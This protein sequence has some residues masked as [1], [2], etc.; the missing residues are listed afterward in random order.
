MDFKGYFC[1]LAGIQFNPLIDICMKRGFIL[2]FLLII[3]LQSCGWSEREKNLIK[4]QKETAEKEQQ[5]LAWEQRLKIKER[6]LEHTK[7]FLDSTQKQIDSTSVYDPAI[8]G[9]WTVKMRCIETSCEG[10]ALGD[11]KI[12]QWDVSY[13]QN[14]VVVKAYSGAVLSRVYMGTYA[15]SMLKILDEQV[16]TGVS[17]SAVLNF[18]NQR[19]IEGTREIE[20]QACKIIYALNAERSK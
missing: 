19:R 11:T 15:N 20:Q 1:K 6:E 4:R 16:D 18:S 14:T 8:I 7:Q 13:N 9:K 3:F 12:E 17:I 5:L 2:I 10:S